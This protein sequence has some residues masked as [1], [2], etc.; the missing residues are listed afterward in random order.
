MSTLV[1][2]R[3][4]FKG[5]SISADSL[6]NGTTEMWAKY[7][8]SGTATVTASHNVSSLTDLGVGAPQL[9]LT[10]ALDIIEGS[11]WNTCGTSGGINYPVQSGGRVSSTTT[12]LG[13]CG[14]NTTG[15][16]DWTEGS[17][18]AIG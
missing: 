7:S 14:S 3:V 1:T 9:N 8:M 11:C 4:G 12:V 10:T 2:E 16:V 5:A 13:Y 15:R 6:I 18:G 17:M